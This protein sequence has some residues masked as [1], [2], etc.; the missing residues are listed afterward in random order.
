MKRA[1]ALCL[2]LLVSTSPLFSAAGS[3]KEVPVPDRLGEADRLY[4]QGL[5]H[6]DKAWDYEKKARGAKKVSDRDV[7][8]KSAE[9]EFKRAID[10]FESAVVQNSRHFEAFGS[11]GY[12]QRKIGMFEEALKSYDR[13]LKMQPE[14]AEA[15]EYRAEAYLNLGR[16]DDAMKDYRKLVQLDDELA[17]DFLDAASEWLG[18]ADRSIPAIQAFARIVES[19]KSKLGH[20]SKKS[21]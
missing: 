5:K 17:R 3:E 4:N 14:Y 21:W 1:T 16:V 20:T 6:R 15:L 10:S 7:Y 19:E 11:L 2:L 8:L 13:A 18:N 9:R 12:A